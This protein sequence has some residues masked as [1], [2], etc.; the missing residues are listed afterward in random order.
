MIE[1]HKKSIDWWKNKLG[2]SEYAL[3][4]ISFAKGII[5]TILFYTFLI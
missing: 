5:L 1:W 2:V 4:W 3:Y